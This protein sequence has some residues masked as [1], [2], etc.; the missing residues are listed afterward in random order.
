MHKYILVLLALIM[1][2]QPVIAEDIDALFKKVDEYIEKKNFP[3]AL[4]ELSWARKEIEKMHQTRLKDFLPE[5][6]A[7][8]KGHKFKTASALGMNSLERKYTMD[9][10]KSVKVMLTGGSGAGANN[11]MGG[12]AGLGKMAAMMQ[13]NTGEAETFRISGR[14]ASL[15]TTRNN[16]ELTVFLDSGSILKLEGQNGADADTLKKMAEAVKIDDLDNYLKGV[17]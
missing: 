14:T 12:L 11:P 6:L 1:I 3:K 17:S 4:E 10:T 2:S 7:G 16:P 8:A 15:A 13:G 9:G 5:E